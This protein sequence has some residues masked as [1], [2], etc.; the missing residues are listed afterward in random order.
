M[1]PY[2]GRESGFNV[3]VTLR[4]VP[5]LQS[6]L[7]FDRSQFVDVA[8]DDAEVFDA[9]VFRAQTTYQVTS[10]LNLRNISQYDT[11]DQTLDLNLLAT[12]RVNAGTV[13]YLGYDDHH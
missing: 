10:R 5:S 2:L 7:S 11:F 1:R 3:N 9:K 6:R 8:L 12:Y 4:P 13:F